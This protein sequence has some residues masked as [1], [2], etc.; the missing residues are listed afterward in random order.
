[1]TNNEVYADIDV[2][3]EN[4]Q[5]TGKATDFFDLH[6]NNL[7]HRSSQIW[8]IEDDNLIFQKRGKNVKMPG[9]LD[10]SVGGHVDTGESP[11][12]CAVRECFEE[13]GLK[14]SEDDLG[15]EY[16]FRICE[17]IKDDW[18]ENEFRHIYFIKRDKFDLTYN[19]EVE[20]LVRVPLKDLKKFHSKNLGILFSEWSN[21]YY[22]F[23]FSILEKKFNIKFD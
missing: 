11:E 7:L 18:F 17:K 1:M 19:D 3:D 9:I 6:N 21:E 4:N 12:A 13:V 8:F 14:I 22:D 15:E 10:A 20:E 16:I 5:L 23:I 2:V